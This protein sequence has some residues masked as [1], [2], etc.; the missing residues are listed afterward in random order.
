MHKSK[1]P[2]KVPLTTKTILF[3]LQECQ[4]SGYVIPKG[5]SVV[6]CSYFANRDVRVFPE[7]D[8]FKPERWTE[9]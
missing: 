3:L 5:M 8:R 6:Y 1:S 2:L 4:V 7:P 9:Q